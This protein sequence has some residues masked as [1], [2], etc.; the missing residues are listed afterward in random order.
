MRTFDTCNFS[1]FKDNFVD[2]GVKHECSTIDCTDSRKSFGNS[3]ETKDGVNERGRVFAH[4]VHVKLDLT[5]EFDGWSVEEAVISIE[6]NGMTDEVDGVLLQ[7]VFFKHDLSRGINLDTVIGL[8][9]PFFEVLNCL[10]ELLA[11]T[12]LKETHE[13]RGES[14]LRCNGNFVDFISSL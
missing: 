12:L 2:I 14:F 10:Q 13:V 9:F 6:S 11:T 3:S 5:D 1:I 4:R 7:T 8:G